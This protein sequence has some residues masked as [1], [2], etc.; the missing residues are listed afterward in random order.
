MTR[1]VVATIDEIKPGG[2]KVV[3]IDDREIVIFNLNGDYVGILNRCPH[4]GG[5]LCDGV[6]TALITSNEPGQINYAR[7]G[8]II[9]CPWHG[10]FF[11]LRSGQ[12]W[13]EPDRIKTRNYNVA[14][15]GGNEL[16]E[17]PY[18][19]ETI[20]VTTDQQYLVVET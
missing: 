18:Q 2:R 1:H 8:E 16:V 4:Q 20:E 13:G 17:G 12:S 19:A 14:V 5:K 11:D 10:W 15:T 9:R 6:V 7:P 3:T